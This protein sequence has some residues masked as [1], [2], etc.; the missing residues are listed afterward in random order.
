M[1]LEPAPAAALTLESLGR[2]LG[3]LAARP[4]PLPKHLYPSAGTLYPVQ[5]YL[6]LPPPGL[7]DLPPGAWYYDPE[8]HA[9]A[10][11][12][13]AP[14]PVPAGDDALFHILLVAEMGAIAPAYPEQAEDFC[15]LEAGY[16]A[17][18]LVAEAAGLRLE[19]ASDPVG[20][21]GAALAVALRLEPGHRPLSAWRGRA[22]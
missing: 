21:D 4:G 19:P 20:W 17:E 11:L 12:G 3:A 2:L 18:A 16:M 22:A 6:S 9:L 10:S 8:A 5:A 13:E 7:P 14:A 1:T 15:L